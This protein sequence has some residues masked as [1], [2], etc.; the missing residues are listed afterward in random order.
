TRVEPKTD[1]FVPVCKASVVEVLALELLTVSTRGT[2]VAPLNVASPLYITVIECVPDARAEVVTLADPA[3]RGRLPEISVV[4][5]KKT[6][7]PVA[8]GGATVAVKVRESPTRAGLVPAVR[9]TAMLL[10][11][12]ITF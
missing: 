7:V 6:T 11:P 10:F 12:L 3:F 8:V 5:S 2:D 1:G 4:P 9:A